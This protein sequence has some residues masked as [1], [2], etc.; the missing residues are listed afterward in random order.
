MAHGTA[1]ITDAGRPGP[2]TIR[3][4]LMLGKVPAPVLAAD[5]AEAF[6]PGPP[7]E[8]STPAPLVTRPSQP[9]RFRAAAAHTSATHRAIASLERNRDLSR[10]PTSTDLNNLIAKI[11]YDDVLRMW[12]WHSTPRVPGVRHPRIDRR[13]R[14]TTPG[15]ERPAAGVGS[16]ATTRRPPLGRRDRAAGTYRRDRMP[17]RIGGS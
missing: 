1:S 4:I 10:A 2:A 12:R 11:L 5:S 17:P 13:G 6:Q 7:P 9:A 8:P 3:A 15:E 16:R 14:G